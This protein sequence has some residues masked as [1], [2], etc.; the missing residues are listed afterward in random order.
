MHCHLHSGKK[1]EERKTMVQAM[2]SSTKKEIVHRKLYTLTNIM[3]GHWTYNE[4]CIVENGKIYLLDHELI[5]VDNHNEKMF[6]NHEIVSTSY[7]ILDFRIKT[8]L[9]LSEWVSE[10]VSGYFVTPMSNVLAMS[11]RERV[12]FSGMM[13][14]AL[15]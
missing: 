10:W 13:M 7:T 12:T 3:N 8:I 15:Y 1:A 14:S 4:E 5:N 6:P 2:P 11:R 9:G